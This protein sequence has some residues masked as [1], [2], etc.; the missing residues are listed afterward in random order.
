MKAEPSPRL[1]V[2]ILE[3]E[4]ASRAASVRES[5]APL[6]EVEPVPGHPRVLLLRAPEAQKQAPPLAELRR[7]AGPH[8]VIQPGLVDAKGELRLPTGRIRVRF[9]HAPS[10]DELEA[11][12][13]RHQLAIRE[14]NRYVPSQVDFGVRADGDEETILD[15]VAAIEDD[16]SVE[17]T[18]PDTL[19]QYRRLD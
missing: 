15:S 12:A 13:S 18:W 10:D 8:V 16:E 2:A 14:R 5:L 6:V 19:Q 3:E 1:F 11:F 7:R 9:R 4:D 17:K